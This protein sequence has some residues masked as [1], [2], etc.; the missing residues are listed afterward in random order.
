LIALHQ[1]IYAGLYR[2]LSETGYGQLVVVGQV[3][4]GIFYLI[5]AVPLLISRIV[6]LQVHERFARDEDALALRLPKGMLRGEISSSSSDRECRVNNWELVARLRKDRDRSEGEN[7]RKD[8]AAITIDFLGRCRPLVVMQ[9]CRHQNLDQ[10][11]ENKQ[12]AG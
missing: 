1:F 10:A 6:P 7:N 4:S 2:L 8:D 11:K 5:A 9:D 12:G 3:A